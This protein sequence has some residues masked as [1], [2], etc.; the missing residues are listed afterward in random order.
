MAGIL[1]SDG[2]VAKSK[3]DKEK[4]SEIE[5]LIEKVNGL[6]KKVKKLEEKNK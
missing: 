6:E 4:K 1:M 5:L 2:K 3:K